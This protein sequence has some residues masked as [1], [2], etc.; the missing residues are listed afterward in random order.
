MSYED[1]I[2]RIASEIPS[3]AGK[4]SAPR[5]VYVK[6]R[7]KTYLTFESTV[8][9]GEKEFLRL[10]KILREALPGRELA[11]RVTSPSLKESFLAEIG[12]YRSVLTD[13]LR[14]NYPA[15]T[16]WLP[17]IGWQNQG[18]RITLTFPNEFSLQYTMRLNVARRLETAIREIF[19][20]D[21]IV[22]ATVSGDREARLEA[23]R[24]ERARDQL[25]V[26]LGEMAARYGT[27]TPAERKE[28]KPARKPAEPKAKSAESRAA[29]ARSLPEGGIPIPD[30]PETAVRRPI[31]GRSVADR[32]VEIRELNSESGLVVIQGDVFMLERK[33]VSGGEMAL[34]SFAVTD[35]TSSV[36]CK[37]F[38]RYRARRAPRGQ[39]ADLPPITDAERQAAEERIARIREGMNVKIRGD[40]QYDTY[41]RELAVMIRDLVEMEKEERRDSAE[42]KRVELHL[43]TNMSTMDALTPVGT[44]ID[45]AVQWGHPAIAVTDHGVLQSFPAAF[46]AAKGKI[47]LIPGCEGY[48]IDERDIVERPGDQPFDG[49]VVVLD[50]ESTGLNTGSARII[51]IGA[52]KLEKGTIVDSFQEL[53]DPGEPLPPKIT[54]IT[55]I[56]DAMLSGRPRAAE[57]LPKFMDFI[58]DCPIAAHNSAFDAAL[59]RAELKRLGREYENPVMD[60]L[61]Y[62]RKLYPQLKSFRL[63]ALCKHLGVSLKNAHR[64]VHDATATAQCLHRMFEETAETHPEIRTYRDLNRHLRG[65]AIGSSWHIILL[66]K[67]RQGLVNL[68]RLVTLSHLEYFRR[69]PHMPR[70]EIQ[71]LREGLILGS[72][73]EAGELFRAVLAGESE[74]KLEEIASFY[75]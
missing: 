67:N 64:A 13:F 69:Q 37:T 66:A 21:V 3:L 31:I 59:L 45:R 6:A 54:E 4:L 20:A 24:R 7:K 17:E 9:V 12:A 57:M 29:A 2:S 75:D 72:A 46:R 50:F 40:C 52:V 32:P 70:Q 55:G 62:A 47:K 26:T 53:V 74:E 22:E 15:M 56:T 65:G 33:E 61:T 42:E 25:T 16:A 27:G 28:E 30:M 38:I 73:C 71:R 48:L 51:E 18:E 60:T 35:Y 58:G 1:L 8:L 41:S 49:P 14:R 68:N 43:H 36:L 10:E 63:G 44:L 34:I 11:V 23:M 19:G 5:A 39:E